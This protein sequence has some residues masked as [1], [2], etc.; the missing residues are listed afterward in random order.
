MEVLSRR[1]L[2]K[3]I[4]AIACASVLAEVMGSSSALASELPTCS[5]NRFRSYEELERAFNEFGKLSDEAVRSLIISHGDGQYSVKSERIPLP[6][7]AAIVSCVLTAAWIFRNGTDRNRVIGQ[8]TEVVV[9]CVG[10][11]LGTTLTL[12]VARLI[13][14]HRR[15]IIAALSAIGLTAAQ[16]APLENAPYPR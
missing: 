8:L 16:L 1:T 14:K 12:K 9:G 7:P 3:A 11:P 10:I 5:P 4:P 2:V 15:R 6:G 13:W